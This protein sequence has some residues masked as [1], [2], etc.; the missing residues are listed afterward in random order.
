ML[1]FVAAA[2]LFAGLLLVA[3]FVVA[4]FWDTWRLQAIAAVT[5]GIFRDRRMGLAAHPRAPCDSPPAFSATLQEF[6]NDI[7]MLKG[8]DERA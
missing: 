8:R 6:E 1:A 7:A 2:F 5:L 4:V 3:F